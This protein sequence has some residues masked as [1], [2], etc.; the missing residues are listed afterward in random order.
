M[1][2]CMPRLLIK[3]FRSRYIVLLDTR[4]LFQKKVKELSEEEKKRRKQITELCKDWKTHTR[5][6]DEWA[7][8]LNNL[9]R[10]I[11][12]ST[13]DDTKDLFRDQVLGK[14]FLFD[15]SCFP[16]NIRYWRQAE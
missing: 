11:R 12:Y 7:N 10:V 8:R 14:A 4:E 1:R 6:D 3:A 16:S 15:K 5:W 2:Q 13:D 9:N